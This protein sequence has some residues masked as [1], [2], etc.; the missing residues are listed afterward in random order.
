MED[1][2]S[3]LLLHLRG[4]WKYRWYAIGVAWLLA[5]AGWT[6]VFSLPND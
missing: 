6:T 5:L 3:D 1:L 2:I 4:I